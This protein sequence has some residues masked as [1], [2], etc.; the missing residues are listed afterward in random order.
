[1]L[2]L[3]KTLSYNDLKYLSKINDETDNMNVCEYI[4]RHESIVNFDS[5]IIEKQNNFIIVEGIHNFIDL[6]LGFISDLPIKKIDILYK[7]NEQ[8]EFIKTIIPEIKYIDVI[9]ES[10]PD[11]IFL[12]NLNNPDTKNNIEKV[13]KKIYKFPKSI[14]RYPFYTIVYKLYFN[15]NLTDVD[16]SNN[17]VF[18]VGVFINEIESRKFIINH[19]MPVEL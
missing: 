14:S 4:E 7:I 5:R 11:G 18:D 13:T 17:K 9:A 12:I 3:D 16:I 1:M 2:I 15:D 10:N 6:I 8:Y 19:N